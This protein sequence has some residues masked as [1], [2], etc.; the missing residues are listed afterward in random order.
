V[1]RLAITG[2]EDT[3]TFG[4]R[5]VGQRLPLLDAIQMPESI[6]L[7]GT[8]R[9]CDATGNSSEVR[10]GALDPYEKLRNLAQLLR[11]LTVG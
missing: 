9:A 5:R 3:V 7:A 6:M 8:A 4:V 10:L 2:F 1:A 11:H